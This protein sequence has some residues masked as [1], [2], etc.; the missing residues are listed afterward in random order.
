MLLN[1]HISADATCFVRKVCGL[2][3][4]TWGTTLGED[5]LGAR[6]RI[7]DTKVVHRACA[8]QT[9]TPCTCMFSP[10]D[11]FPSFFVTLGGHRGKKR[12]LP[13]GKSCR[14]IFGAHTFGSQ[15]PLPPIL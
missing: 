7:L 13:S 4:P 14:A 12:N 6:D 9:F 11:C 5:K 8:R 1:S 2:V 3:Q 10:Q 15:S